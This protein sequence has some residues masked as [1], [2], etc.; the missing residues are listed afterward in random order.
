MIPANWPYSQETYETFNAIDRAGFTHYCC[1]DRR[2][3][4][5]LVEA[6]DWGD[7]IDL[8]NIRGADRATAARVPQYDGLDIFAPSQAVWHHL[9]TLEPTVAAIL[10]LPPPHHPNA[11]TVTHPAPL[12]L[13]VPSH[14][15]RPMTIKPGKQRVRWRS[16]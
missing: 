7:Y 2:A 8:I 15:Q 11:P 3:P 16:G 12:T 5:V 4:Y 14:E 13:F 1:G 9:G 6:Y 10:R